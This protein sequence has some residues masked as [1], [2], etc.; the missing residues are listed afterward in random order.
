MFI[1]DLPKKLEANFHL[2]VSI[3]PRIKKDASVEIGYGT[4]VNTVP[5]EKA[6]EFLK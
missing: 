6:A 2:H 1:H 5:P 4:K 3:Q